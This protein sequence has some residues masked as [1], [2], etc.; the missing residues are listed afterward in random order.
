MENLIQ[1]QNNRN[2]E[3]DS[4]YEYSD[5]TFIKSAPENGGEIQNLRLS[6]IEVYYS[7][8]VQIDSER[9]I[10]ID[11]NNITY[12]FLNFT[13]ILQQRDTWQMFIPLDVLTGSTSHF[14][15][16]IYVRD[17]ENKVVKGN[18]GTGEDSYYEA[19]YYCY[20]GYPQM[21]VSPSEGKYNYLDNLIFSCNKGI[22]IKDELEEIY[23]LGEDKSTVIQKI[24]ADELISYDNSKSYKYQFKN[25]IKTEG[26]YYLYIPEGFFVLGN[27]LLDNGDIQIEYNIVSKQESYGVTLDPDET[28][29]LASLST[30][31]ITFNDQNVVVPY[32]G[33]SKRITVTNELGDIITYA[34][35]SFDEN[36]TQNNICIIKLDSTI[37]TSG[38]YTVNVPEKAFFFGENAD[39]TSI[40]MYFTYTIT[41]VPDTV[42]SDIGVRTEI[43]ENNALRFIYLS[44]NNCNIVLLTQENSEV[45][46][47][48][49]SEQLIAKGILKLAS[50]KR[51]LY[52]EIEPEYQVTNSGNYTLIISEGL[53]KFSSTVYDKELRITIPF[54]T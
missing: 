4:N 33:N 29:E 14:K 53:L 22:E 44:F 30:I 36:R 25:P 1:P 42:V 5:V 9:S 48:D 27:R 26:I 51:N 15:V 52:V 46:L 16:N 10:I 21:L 7:G 19:K 37:K 50:G 17:L 11:E 54:N 20:F 40:P 24:R 13:P 34:S 32:Y 41:E 39:S 43:D 35:A 8:E 2:N 38:K 23:I 12:P 18:R 49:E 31:N 28:D 3:D 45:T 6:F 47:V